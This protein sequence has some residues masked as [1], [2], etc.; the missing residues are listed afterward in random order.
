MRIVFASLLLAAAH[1]VSADDLSQRVTAAD[2][3]VSWQVPRVAD[4]GDACCHT[5]HGSV[6]SRR[7]CDLDGKQWNITSTAE[8]RGS[9]GDLI[10]YAHV[11]RGA[12]DQIRAFSATC[13]VRSADPLRSLDAVDP[14]A[15]VGWL[16]A[17]AKRESST[18]D[19]DAAVAALAMHATPAAMTALRDLAVAERPQKQ[20]EA[21]LFWMGQAR[22]A[23]GAAAVERYARE[24]ADAHIR[25]HSVFVLSQ[26]PE[27][28]TYP[29]ILAI[30]GSDRS[31][32]VRSQSLF[33]LA[34]MKDKRATADILAALR[35]EQDAEVRE[36]AV[37]ALSQLEDGEADRALI[38]VIRGDFPREVKQKAVFWLGQSGSDEALT[39]IDEVLK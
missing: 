31:T 33:W 35:R 23:E 5:I 30:A 37:F 13:P 1:A 11:K 7:G 15:S 12:V 16:A 3:W 27:Y 2:G 38:A 17:Q 9:A 36:Q 32:E 20:R 21:S 8:S 18:K 26:S 34:Q 22:G 4:S 29:K 25:E 6:V 10:V 19:D 28:D 14:A 39:F 24:D